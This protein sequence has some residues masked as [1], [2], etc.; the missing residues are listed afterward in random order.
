MAKQNIY[1]NDSFF[2][3]FKNL[4]NNKINFNDCIET[5]ILLA[6]IPEVD[7]KRVLD[8]GCG[9]GQHAKQYS[10]M[11]AESVLGIDI[12]EKMLEYAKE[13]FHAKNITYRQMALEDICQID[14]QFDLITSSLA[15]EYDIQKSQFIVPD[16]RISEFGDT[17]VIVYRPQAF[18][19]R[20]CQEMLGRFGNDFW[21]SFMR[22]DYDVDF[23][24]ERPYDEFSKA[25][26]YSWQKE[27]RIALDLAQGKFDPD[28]ISNITDF[29]RLTFP[30]KIEEDTNPDSLADSIT[31][32]IGDTRD[33]SISVPV[34]TLFDGKAIESH[35]PKDAL[36]PYSITPLI[37]PRPPKPTFFKLVSQLP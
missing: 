18:L 26:S 34:F 33:I 1:D 13:H 9:M 19:Y 31:L 3:N 21:T 22:V 7:G 12:S 27:F 8:I 36:P 4:R 5:P 23:S 30:G 6:M 25:P 15:L 35:I 29:A 24:T 17:A 11:G 37:V 28:T 32:N 14:E 10:D 2:E 16:E 20:V